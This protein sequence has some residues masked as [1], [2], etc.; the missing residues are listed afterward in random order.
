MKKQDIKKFICPFNSTIFEALKIINGNAKGIAFIAND[1]NNLIGVVTDGDIRRA[2]IKGINL[3]EKVS[4]VINREFV[5]SREGE[6]IEDLF[7]KINSKVKIIPIVNSKFEVVNYFEFK[8]EIKIPVASPDLSGNELKYLIDAFLSSWISSKGEYVREFE[9]RFSNYCGCKYGVSTS[10]GTTALHLAL[11]SL[12]IKKGDEVII[13]DLTFAATANAVIYTGATPV[14][15][16][17][18]K[19]SWCIDPKKIYGALSNRTKAIIPVHL[20]GQPANMKKILEIS[21]KFNLF[22]IEDC[23]EA[24][25]AEF[26]SKKVGCFGDIGCFSLFGNKIITTGEGGICVTNSKRLY[27]K[28]RLLRDHGMDI[29]NKYKHTV[30]GFNYRMTNLQAAIGLAQL[31]RVEEI[32]KKRRE[33]EDT[34]R[35]YLKDI[36]FIE[37][38]KDIPKRGKVTWLVSI[39][40]NNNKR[41]E[42]LK[43]L[44][45]ENIEVRPFFYPLSSMRIYRKFGKSN[46]VSKNISRK[47]MNLPTIK[48]LEERDYQ[49]IKKLFATFKD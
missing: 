23:A 47:G 49:K 2:L 20:Y 39:L 14:I 36:D 34:Y 7:N 37:F 17:I 21:R 38:Q 42:I 9:E 4:K 29:H 24:L 11:T 40:I 35:N 28:M 43:K 48:D 46:P 44:I 30:V 18:E 25:G 41:K 8:S 12:G 26:N 45:E 32:I 3:E 13:P 22:V 1:H 6:S 31:E 27:K 16:D 19:D 5:Y 10:N 15:V 33:I